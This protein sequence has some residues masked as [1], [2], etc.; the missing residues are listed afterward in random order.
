MGLP[1]LR[2]PQALKSLRAPRM[3]S[4]QQFTIALLVI[5]LLVLGILM[6]LY[7]FTP[8]E[9]AYRAQSVR[10]METVL[11][12]LPSPP[13]APA[14]KRQI[15]ERPT[16]NTVFDGYDEGITCPE[17]QEHYRAVA[18]Q[19]D[20]TVTRAPPSLPYGDATYAKVVQSYRL[21]LEI[22]CN[23]SD[24]LSVSYDVSLAN[25]FPY[26]LAF[27]GWLQPHTPAK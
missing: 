4:L 22:D 11:D 17:V 10:V 1:A 13:G 16:G 23:I 25:D 12:Q 14:A 2:D 5:A 19:D 9:V 8:W 15:H 18:T 20:W 26:S 3:P 7:T 21:T 24:G 27:I 6:A